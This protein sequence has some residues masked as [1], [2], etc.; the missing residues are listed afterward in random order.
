LSIECVVVTDNLEVIENDACSTSTSELRRE[1]V[2]LRSSVNCTFQFK[3]SLRNIEMFTWNEFE[4]VVGV[5]PLEIEFS[6][7]NTILF[8]STPLVLPDE[9]S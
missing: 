4:K 1:S 7:E 9:S 8:S 6:S 3:D 5:A 2:G